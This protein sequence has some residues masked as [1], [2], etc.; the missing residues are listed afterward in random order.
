[1]RKF[2][3]EDLL[4]HSGI[5][6][7]VNRVIEFDEENMVTEVIVRDD[8]LFGDGNTVPAWLGIEYMAQTIA[9]LGG[10]KRRLAGE[11]LNLGF[12]LGTRRYVCNVGTFAVGSILSVSIKQLVEDQGLGVFDC[13]I[14]AEGISASAK[15]NVYQPD[16]AI[17]R[18]VTN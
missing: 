1:M 13:R 4:P 17:N 6:V 10:M 9:A 8:G 11:P 5:M 7:L 16:S 14:S 15:L 2:A 18:V 12:L 3:V